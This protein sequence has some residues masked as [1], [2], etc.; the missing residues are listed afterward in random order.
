MTDVELLVR[1]TL[2]RH[3][4]EVPAMDLVEASSVAARAR[5]RQVMNAVS[6]GI[7][8]V[9]IALGLITG[10]GAILRAE[11]RRPAAQP[12]PTPTIPP[13]PTQDAAVGR[14]GFAPT[15]AAPSLP[16]SGDAVITVNSE[17]SS[18]E[19]EGTQT[20]IM[21][22]ADGRMIWRRDR[23]DFDGAWGACEPLVR[24]DLEREP[25]TGWVEQR[26]TRE[27]ITMLR[28]E[29]I[30]TGFFERDH[31][32]E[33]PFD[34]LIDWFTVT[35]AIDDRI[36]TL[37]TNSNLLTEPLSSRQSEALS[38]ME[39]LVADPNTTLPDS[40][41]ADRRITAFVP[42]SYTFT[43]RYEPTPADLAEL[44]PPADGLIDRACGTVTTGEARS[45][46]QALDAANIR[47]ID[48]DR[49]SIAYKWGGDQERQQF[50]LEPLLPDGVSRC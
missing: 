32:I 20:Q 34:D 48:T 37:R 2:A 40:A 24:S 10:V 4:A 11:G 46:V 39:D 7:A 27:T 36:T 31:E 18:G 47:R 12:T 44:P 6:A 22:F 28:E 23:C 5:T 17:S 13:P 19:H 29:L 35:L 25:L 45:I 50:R 42:S 38:R 26:L 21:I 8:A 49:S 3:E 1:E 41:F 16:L 9:I 43:F 30:A 33:K 15:D 14:V